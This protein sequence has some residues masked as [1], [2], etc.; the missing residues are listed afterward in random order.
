[1]G[2]GRRREEGG[3]VPVETALLVEELEQEG[4]GRL[5]VDLGRGGEG[6]GGR[7]CGG[8]VKCVGCIGGGVWGWSRV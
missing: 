4:R 2:G 3:G 5:A 1:M 8:G 7:H 6:A